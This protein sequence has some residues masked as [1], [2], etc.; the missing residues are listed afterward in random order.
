MS[1]QNPNN[2]NF[3]FTAASTNAPSTVQINAIMRN[4]YMLMGLGLLTTAV[5]AFLVA[6]TPALLS[7]A[8]APGMWIIALVLQLGIVV[9]LSAGVSR[10]WLSPNGAAL[11]FFAYSGITGFS[12]SLVFLYFVTVDPNALFMAFVSAAALFGTMTMFAL[13][14]KMDLSKWGTYLIMGLVGLVIV[15]FVNILIGSST[16]GLI[17][18]WF[19]VILF[20]GLTAY[21]TQR[22]REMSYQLEMQ[23]DSALTAKVSILGALSLYLD[24]I[25]LFLFLLQIFGGSRD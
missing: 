15:S 21:D 9:A 16:L 11:G 5:V 23:G 7:L 14:T 12:L 1:F 19:G 13:T 20:S 10:S 18:S 3:A 2:R 8:T 24:F 6:N 25:N 17:M 22:I 4:V